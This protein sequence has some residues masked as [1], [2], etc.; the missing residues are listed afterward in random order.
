MR[1]GAPTPVQVKRGELERCDG[2]LSDARSRLDDA[3]ERTRTFPADRELDDL[4]PL[5]LEI[6]RLRSRRDRLAAE[7]EAVE[8]EWERA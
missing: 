7:L 1:A 4:Q 8:A 3:A 6:A 5:S 2:A